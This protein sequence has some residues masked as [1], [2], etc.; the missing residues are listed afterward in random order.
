M[1][2]RDE[3]GHV[4]F[5]LTVI[6]ITVFPLIMIYD[7]L[8]DLGFVVQ[9]IPTESARKF[10]ED[11]IS[12]AKLGVSMLMIPLISSLMGWGFEIRNRMR[13][14]D[15]EKTEKSKNDR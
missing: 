7:S 1:N 14:D 5:F 2:M 13:K 8:Q 6:M 4:L 12:N 15:H 9:D 3:N 11:E 10:A